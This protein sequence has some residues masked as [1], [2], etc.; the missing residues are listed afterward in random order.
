MKIQA[1]INRVYA[2]WFAVEIP[3]QAVSASLEVF[4]KNVPNA[5]K[6][7][8]QKI[9]R[10]K[11]KIH[12]LTV[13]APPELKH[14]KARRQLPSPNTYQ[15]RLFEIE[16]LGIGYARSFFAKTYFIVCASEM[17][18]AFRKK[19]G[20]SEATFHITLGFYPHDIYNVAKS[21][22]LWPS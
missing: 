7:I 17:L 3:N 21:K 9:K 2:D 4:R 12:H 11:S 14:L 1:T 5:E 22:V 6:L 10:D 19:L 13:I 16:M 15:N 20:L 8:S 18:Q